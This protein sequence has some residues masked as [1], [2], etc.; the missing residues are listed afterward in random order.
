MRNF[1]LNLRNSPHGMRYAGA[2]ALATVAYAAGFLTAVFVSPVPRISVPP[3][4]LQWPIDR[5]QNVRIL[6]KTQPR[7]F[8]VRIP[9]DVNPGESDRIAWLSFCV[10]DPPYDPPFKPGMLLTKLYVE[11]RSSCLSLAS[12]AAG[13]TIERDDQGQVVLAK[14]ETAP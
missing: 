5:Y 3:P 10:E 9:S 4:G 11:N 1:E 12:H 8:Q 6:R 7:V 2:M 14:G 13:Y